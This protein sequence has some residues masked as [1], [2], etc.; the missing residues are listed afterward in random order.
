MNTSVTE[1]NIER[2]PEMALPFAPPS[3]GDKAETPCLQIAYLLSEEHKN[4][5][6]TREV[7][8]RL[9]RELPAQVLAAF[10]KEG[11][12]ARLEL[13]K[14]RFMIYELKFANPLSSAVEHEY[15]A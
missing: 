7:R 15:R 12:A 8:E 6:D 2:I 10:G 11:S 5:A 4:A 1:P 9:L 14:V 3:S 13:H